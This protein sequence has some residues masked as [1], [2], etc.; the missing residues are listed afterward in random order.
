ME[1]S[2]LHMLVA[3]FIFAVTFV[4]ILSERLHRTLAGFAG[5]VVMLVVGMMMGFYSQGEALE[6]IDFNTMGLLFG[7]M[8]LVAILGRTGAFEYLAIAT[9]KAT[10]GDPWLLTVAFGTVTTLVSMMLDNVTTIILIAPVTLLVAERLAISPI[11]LLMAE[12]ILSDVGGVATL[13]GDP[14]NMIIGSAAGFSF[15]DFLIHLMPIVLVA[16]VVTMGVLRFVFRK[17]LAVP[18]QHLDALLA[19]DPREALND[20]PMLKKI[21]L[22]LG[23]VIALFFLHDTLGLMPATV[24][25]IGVGIAF[26][27]IRPKPEEVLKEVEWSVLVFFAALFV[28]VGGVAATGLMRLLAEQIVGVAREQPVLAIIA[29]LW[30]SA[31]LSAIVDNIPFTV[32]MVPV[33]QALKAQGI[34]VDY[35]WWALALGVGFGGNGTPIGSTANVVTV[36][37]SEKTATP[38]TFRIWLKAGSATAVATCIVGTILILLYYKF[39]G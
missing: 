19:M 10:K 24:T 37:M 12:A 18:P 26:I 3:G 4:L 28:V 20:R 25:M 32:A 14:P 16:L 27:L 2:T 13:V 17:E 6:A 7:M 35:L 23:V 31:L 38:I 29:V 9:A 8:V 11:P 5:A 30:I 39:V 36:A 15:N 22:A 33:I 34:E 21:L 1:Y